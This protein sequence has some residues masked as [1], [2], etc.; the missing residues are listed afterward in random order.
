[1][2]AEKEAKQ[3]AVAEKRAERAARK[4]GREAEKDKPLLEVVESDGDERLPR[5][6]TRR[7]SAARQPAASDAD[8]PDA[9]AAGRGA[10]I[11]GEGRARPST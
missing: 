10:G 3:A 2:Q 11:G 7:R 1:M 6:W 5:S 4:A 8:A 9:P